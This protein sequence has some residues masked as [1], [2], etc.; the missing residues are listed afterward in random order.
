MIKN[1][2]FDL[3]NVLVHV[4]FEKFRTG[5]LT[6]GVSEKDFNVFFN[7]N[8]VRGR[9]EKGLLTTRE[10]LRLAVKK[11]GNRLTQKQLVPIF[12]DMF[13]ENPDMKAFLKKLVKNNKYNLIMLSNTNPIHYNYGK[14]HFQY[15]YLIKKRALSYKLKLTKPDNRIYVKVFK[16][17]HIKPD[18]TLFIDDKQ[19]NCAA[20]ELC[21]MKTIHF[22][23][24]ESF[25]KQF[26]MI[27]ANKEN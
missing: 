20:A 26:K 3:G 14:K 5:L 10:F 24:Y 16:R 11:L 9:F 19:I 8:L 18:E 12:Q 27:T 1:I 4:D 21:G 25:I 22:I 15:I 17:Y 2:I 7:S 13:E 23:D 6:A